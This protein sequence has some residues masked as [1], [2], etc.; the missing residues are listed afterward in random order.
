MWKPQNLLIIITILK[1]TLRKVYI[2]I[3]D[4]NLFN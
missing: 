2:T 1:L 3:R 4:I